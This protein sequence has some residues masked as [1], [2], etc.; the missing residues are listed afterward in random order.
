MQAKT[1][2]KRG[3]VWGLAFAVTMTISSIWGQAVSSGQFVRAAQVEVTP[4]PAAQQTNTPQMDPTAVPTSTPAS[5]QVTKTPTMK[6]HP[7]TT[8]KPNAYGTIK[9]ERYRK[10]LSKGFLGKRYGTVVDGIRCDCS[11]Y[12]RAAIGR[13]KS[14]SA[15]TALPFKSYK[16][17]ALT[18]RDWVKGSKVA[19][20]SGQKTMTGRI[21]W[22]KTRSKGAIGRNTQ[23]HS[24]VST[25]E[26]GDVMLYGKNGNPT[27]I[28]LYYG[29]F[30]SAKKVKNFLEKKGY[31]KKGA[32]KKVSKN[33]Y[34]YRGRTII[35]AYSKSKYWRI[36]STNSGILL[37]NDIRGINPF[38]RSFGKWSWT[39]E[40]GLKTE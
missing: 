21:L 13:M 20:L 30:S 2:H 15:K 18:T 25:L 16:V 23:N 5:A 6:F 10:V 9:L 28:A 33:K 17:K 32:I 29:K 3:F 27:H 36:H 40:T 34:T 4:V 19:Y 38:T 12:V 35:R 7:T 8:A 37:D 1:D 14:V 22:N 11:G 24:A 31:V 26:F 39:F